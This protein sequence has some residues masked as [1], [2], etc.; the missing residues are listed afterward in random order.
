MCSHYYSHDAIHPQS[1]PSEIIR[2]SRS[3]AEHRRVHEQPENPFSNLGG[4]SESTK[5]FAT[6][7]IAK[8]RQVAFRRH[9]IP[10]PLRIPFFIDVD[11]FEFFQTSD[12]DQILSF[13]GGYGLRLT[14]ANQFIGQLDSNIRDSIFGN[15]GSFIVFCVSQ[16]DAQHLENIPNSEKAI[17]TSEVPCVIQSRRGKSLSLRRRHHHRHRPKTLAQITSGN[18][19][20]L[21][22]LAKLRQ[23]HILQGWQA[24]AKRNPN[25]RMTRSKRAVLVKSWPYYFVLRSKEVAKL[26]RKRVPTKND[27]GP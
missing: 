14:L 22:T 9:N 26:I 18:A 10:E 12:F 4:I 21:C 5:I 27:I 20:S 16:D 11:E 13:A 1:V 25:L 24:A 2:L 23:S 8:M 3:S 15:V 17:P 7:L 19:R 6:L